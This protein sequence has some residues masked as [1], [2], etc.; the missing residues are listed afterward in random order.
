MPTR[1]ILIVFLIMII[2]SAC[3]QPVA[4]TLDPNTAMTQAFATVNA[5]ST[6]TAL[7]VPTYTPTATPYPTVITTPIIPGLIQRNITYC[8]NTVPL[9]M[10]VYF[11]TAGSGPSPVLIYIHGGAW[12]IGDKAVGFQLEEIPTIAAAGYFIA[13]I[14]YRL[15][16]DYPFPAM[17]EDAKCAV[18]FLRAHAQE[19]NINPD[20]IGV[21]GVSAGGHI[22]SLLGLADEIAGWETGQY[23]EQSSRVQAVVDLWGPSDFTDPTFAEKLQ[24]RGYQLFPN[25]SPDQNMLASASPITYV[26]ADDPPFL[27]VH[28][29]QDAVVPPSQ[30]Q[31]LYDS[32][33]AVGVPAFLQMVTNAGHNLV[34]AGGPISPTRKQVTEIYIQFLDYFLKGAQ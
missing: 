17:I 12:M 14:D 20:K 5:A 16:P 28:G 26:S 33:I 24:K 6:Q 18:R 27:I 29:D 34:S 11:P 7:A 23:L 31:A 21:L 22:A 19:L 8:E 25:V 32:L 15:A 4:P 13:S 30:S 9:E 2:T 1:T 10:D 3:G